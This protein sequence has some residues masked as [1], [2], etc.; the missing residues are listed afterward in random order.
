MVGDEAASAST[1]VLQAAGVERIA[2]DLVLR[3]SVAQH[4]GICSADLMIELA[5]GFRLRAGDG[6]KSRRELA[7]HKPRIRAGCEKAID[8][9][10][11]CR[12]CPYH[13]APGCAPARTPCNKT[14]DSSRWVRQ[15]RS[16]CGND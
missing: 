16:P 11:D 2:G 10:N 15:S 7:C 5:G 12:I 3:E 13:S 6:E 4:K 14:C 1:G 9:G 8:A